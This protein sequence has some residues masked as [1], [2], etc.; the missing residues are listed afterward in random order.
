MYNSV[1]VRF[2]MKIWNT[3]ESWYENS[4]VN[5]IG[6]SI[7][8]FFKTIS[9]GS[10]AKEIFTEDVDIIENTLFYRIY[11][12]LVDIY[13]NIFK[14]MNDGLKPAKENSIYSK[15]VNGLF[16]N[17]LELIKTFS[18]FFMFFGIGIIINSFIRGIFLSGAVIG[19]II[20]ILLGLFILYL[21]E[22]VIVI[23]ENSWF[24]N[25]IINIFKVEEGGDQ[26][27]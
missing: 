8:K 2:L 18:I 7:S 14:K 23:L 24:V 25:F 3:L 16:K 20:L 1:L 11:S 4:L 15:T 12:K 19:S 22:L 6:N 9:K 5:K 10:V 26:W 21:D 17:N 27:W 13:N